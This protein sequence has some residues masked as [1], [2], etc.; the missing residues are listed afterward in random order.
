MLEED[1]SIPVYLA[2]CTNLKFIPKTRANINI[3]FIKR[4]DNAMI[5]SN[6]ENVDN[7]ALNLIGKVLG[8]V[9]NKVFKNNLY[10]SAGYNTI[11]IL[12]N[13][14]YYPCHMFVGNK[15]YKIGNI[16]DDENKLSFKDILQKNNVE[17]CKQCWASEFC[18][19]CTWKMINDDIGSCDEKKAIIEHIIL[20]YI[21]LSTEDKENLVERCRH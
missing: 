1:F 2:E 3:D 21:N 19:N 6:N 12:G 9:N 18:Y 4:I 15:N 16:L 14:D 5:S 17:L 7:I 10:C 13:G 11:S 8:I 20:S